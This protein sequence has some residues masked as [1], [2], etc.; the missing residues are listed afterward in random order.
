MVQIHAEGRGASL[1]DEIRM[2]KLSR[3]RDYLIVRCNFAIR[4]SDFVIP[5][6]L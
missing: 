3:S 1:N 6:P 4:H 2:S 5:F